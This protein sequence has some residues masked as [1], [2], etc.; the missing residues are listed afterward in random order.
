MRRIVLTFGLIAGGILSAMM[1]ITLAFQ[2]QI[3]FDKGAIIGYTTMVLAFLMVYFGV[4]SYRDNVAGGSVTFGRALKVGLLITAVAS[5]C[6][7]ATWEVIYYRFA[8]DFS[9]KYAA[10][11]LERAKAS[12]A[13]QEEL[14]EK[15]QQMAHFKEMYRNPVINVALTLLEPL[16]VGL[17]FTVAAAGL[18][19]RKRRTEE[20]AV[21]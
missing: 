4:R 11:A 17:V 10:Y 18:L 3:G 21:A 15:T 2:E 16:P 20:V 8:P 5:A 7:V 14:A 1:I 12:G 19:S 6:Y 13:T 9:D